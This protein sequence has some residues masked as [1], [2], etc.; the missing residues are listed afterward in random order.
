MI[1]HPN[2]SASI[3]QEQGHTPN[4]HDTITPKKVNVDII[5]PY[6]QFSAIAPQNVP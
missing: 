1:L 2:I 6:I 3:S 5:L 4:N